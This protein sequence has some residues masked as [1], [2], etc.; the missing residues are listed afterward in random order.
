MKKMLLLFVSILAL[1]V[2]GSAQ[3]R[4]CGIPEDFEL[5]V[6]FRP[7]FLTGDG[8]V[9]IIKIRD[10]YRILLHDFRLGYRTEGEDTTAD[11]DPLKEYD[12][13]REDFEHFWH[14]SGGKALLKIQDNMRRGVDGINVH[15]H[16]R[17]RKK[18]NTFMFWSPYRAKRYR[19]EYKLLD[20]LFDLLAR[21]FP[22]GEH[23]KYLE[24][25]K[26]YYFDY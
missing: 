12:I 14:Q 10:S 22:E 4:T 5:R 13:D 2:S 17:T 24:E 19:K 16:A 6:A 15:V 18:S 23:R 7:A 26:D 25:L 1:S 11:E 20:A 8:D 9:Y 3:R 21:K